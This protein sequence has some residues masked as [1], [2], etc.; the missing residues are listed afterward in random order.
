MSLLRQAFTL[1]TALS[2]VKAQYFDGYETVGAVEPVQM[3][4]AYQGPNSMKVCSEAICCQRE[5]VL[6][7]NLIIV[8]WNTFTQLTN[9]TVNYG[10]TPDALTQTASSS[11]SVTYQSSLTWNNHVNITGLLPFTTYYYLPENSNTTTP[12]S[13]TTARAAGIV[14]SMKRLIC[15]PTHNH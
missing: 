5:V 1:V 12:Y 3:R 15:L 9:P 14:V 4:L 6:T 2:G 8:S 11:V 7:N 10:L 13:F